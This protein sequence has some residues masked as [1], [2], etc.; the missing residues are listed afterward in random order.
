MW[1]IA[2]DAQSWRP[3]SLLTRVLQIDGTL[4]AKSGNNSATGIAGWPQIPPLPSYGNSRDGA[5]LQ[6]QAFVY[7]NTATDLAITGSG[8]FD[9]IW[10]LC[11]R[12]SPSP[13]MPHAPCHVLYFTPGSV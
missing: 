7:A 5:Y 3:P 4:R 1:R 13:A 8:H 6:F 12:I 2:T 10:G 11:S 9:I